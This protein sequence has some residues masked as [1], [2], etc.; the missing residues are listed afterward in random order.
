L[1]KYNRIIGIIGLGYVGLSLAYLSQKSF[2][3][4][5]F[6][7]DKKKIDKLNNKISY[8]ND[9][10]FNKNKFNFKKSFFPTSDFKKLI[11]CDYIIICVPT[12]LKKDNKTPD[13]SF[14][15]KIINEIS[16][17]DYKE[18]TIVLESTSWPGT[19]KELIITKLEKKNLIC[20]KDFYVCFSPERIN[21]GD[22]YDKYIKT[23]KI[24]GAEDKNSLNKGL[25]FYKKI[26]K[27]IIIASSCSVAEASKLY[28]NTFRS[29]NISFANELKYI[30][31]DLKI[32]IWEVIDICKTKPFGFIPFYPGAGIGGHCIPI[33]PL[34]LLWKLKKEK[35]SSKVINLTTKINES[36]PYKIVKIIKKE[37]KKSKL[38]ILILGISY[39]KNIN[40]LRESAAL[41]IMKLFRKNKIN[42]KY[43][44]KFFNNIK[45]K[46]NTDIQNRS[47]K[48]TKKNLSK[49]D[50]VLLITD[51]DKVNYDYIFKNSKNIFDTKNLVLKKYPKYS[52]KTIK[53]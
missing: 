23:P 12:P 20:G 19:T 34:Y 15:T 6:D 3:T 48:I 44:D 7:I 40:D 26:F 18:K 39:K 14:I 51:H 25:Y 13:T 38:S 5:G 28:E 10:D 4:F 42:F 46:F 36:I 33:D 1:L 29:I 41:K 22:D 52:Y 24:V 11:L 17:I 27:K 47:M 37:I 45:L 2:K 16:K 43:H 31:K 8:I 53:L 30:L 32:D 21:P 35:L 9:I 50:G 49:F